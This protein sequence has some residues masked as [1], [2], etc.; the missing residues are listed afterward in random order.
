MDKRFLEILKE[1]MTSSH[2]MRKRLNTCGGMAGFIEEELYFKKL[3][4]HQ[5]VRHIR[6]VMVQFKRNSSF[7]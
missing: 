7:R 5:E 3:Q 2:L 6:G 1:T 4:I